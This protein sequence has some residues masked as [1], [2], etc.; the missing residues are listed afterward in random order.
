MGSRSRNPPP[1]FSFFPF[2]PLLYSPNK[3]SEA[4]LEPKNKLIQGAKTQTGE[5]HH[6]YSGHF[7]EITGV[8]LVVAPGQQQNMAV[9]VG[10]DGTIRR[11]SLHPAKLEDARRKMAQEAENGGDGEEEGE[12][13][14]TL[15]TEEEERELAE[16][17][18]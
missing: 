8:V 17:M 13:K 16:L 9:T 4:R 7:D 5:L 2:F 15:M 14:G 10:L 1:L 12:E 18:D 11:W 3:P 6:V